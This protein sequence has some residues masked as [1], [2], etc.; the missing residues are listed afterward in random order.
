[1]C[2]GACVDE[3]T[4]DNNC[5]ACGQTCAGTCQAGRCVRVLDNTT[6]AVEVLAQNATHLFWMETNGEVDQGSKGTASSITLATDASAT[7]LTADAS[8]VYWP[9]GDAIEI[10]AIG[11]SDSTSQSVPSTATE[12]ASDG[13]YVY[14]A[15]GTGIRR[16]PS[17]GG[18]VANIVADAAP[19]ALATSNGLLFWANGAYALERANADGTSQ[20]TLATMSASIDHVATDGTNVYFTSGSDVLSVPVQASALPLVLV[21]G[22]VG[23]V[24]LATDGNDVYWVDASSISKVP[25]GG[26]AATKIYA[27]TGDVVQIV[28]DSAAL[29]WASSAGQ[30]GRLTPK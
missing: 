26:G 2:G 19:H 25:I 24:S 4:D 11:G 6:S 18:T 3:L 8:N 14:V 10:V 16:F 22:I 9:N 13:S 30:I 15:D 21:S 20:S 29:Y 1:M 27:Q 5:G 7:S 17:G 23:L 12:V 28:V